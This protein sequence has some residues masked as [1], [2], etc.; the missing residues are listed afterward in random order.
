LRL[1]SSSGTALLYFI[2][3]YFTLITLLYITYTG[4]NLEA[5]QMNK[6]WFPSSSGFGSLDAASGVLQDSFTSPEVERVLVGSGHG[7]ESIPVSL[8]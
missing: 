8:P 3:L 5:Q 7:Q 6:R 4:N 2:L 1:H